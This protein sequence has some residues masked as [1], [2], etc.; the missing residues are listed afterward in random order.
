MPGQ[1]IASTS[2]QSILSS[3]GPIHQAGLPHV[4]ES[5]G[6]P[7]GIGC[8]LP[9]RQQ[10]FLFLIRDAQHLSHILSKRLERV[11][12]S[13]LERAEQRTHNGLEVWDGHG[14]VRGQ[15]KDPGQFRISQNWIGPPGCTLQD[16]LFVPPPHD[17]QMI[18]ALADW[19]R[20]LNDHDLD[21]P[22]LIAC[23]L[24]HYQFETIHPFLD[25][26]GRMGRLVIILYLIQ[27]G[28]LP[29][30]LLYLSPYFE[31]YRSR[32]YE[33]LQAVRERAEMQEWLRYFLTGVAVQANDAVARAERLLGLQ[34]RYREGL[35]KDR[36]RASEVVNL[37]F[38]N[39]Y[40]TTRRVMEALGVTNAG[41]NNLIR[42]LEDKDWLRRD[43][44][45]GRGGRITWVAPAIMDILTDAPTSETQ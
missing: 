10:L 27:I 21:V 20:Y 5:P 11:R 38:D 17:P 36:S 39:P 1:H 29:Q 40:V 34:S 13:V 31:R 19:E 28:E 8:L 24:L 15:E 2:G 25:G 23:A 41:A 16:A 6:D 4:C 45:S 35:A 32:Y 26:N 43:R 18:D 14:Q 33:R 42:R 37:L 12:I 30:P 7:V 44:V 9:T 3:S 22:P